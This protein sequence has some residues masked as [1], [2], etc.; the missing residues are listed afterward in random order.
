MGW[1]AGAGEGECQGP[2]SS[3]E[4]CAA[5][6]SKNLLSFLVP[7]F[8]SYKVQPLQPPARLPFPSTPLVRE[9]CAS[10]RETPCLLRLACL[11][12]CTDS[13]V[14]LPAYARACTV[15]VCVPVCIRRCSLVC[16]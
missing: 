8:K 1:A 13:F 11:Q 12:T 4:T 2:C 14:T 15:C 9:L 16:T 5:Q 3:L 7:T 10:E 6:R